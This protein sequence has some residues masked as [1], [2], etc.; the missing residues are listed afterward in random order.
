MKKIAYIEVDTHAEIARNFM[1]LM[2]GSTEFSVDYYFSKKI[3][4][5]FGV[6]LPNVHETES[7]ALLE[8]LKNKQ[9]DLLII[10]TVHRY[11]NVFEKITVQ[12]NTAVIVHNLNFTKISRFQLLKSLLKEDFTYRLKLLLKESLL[13]AP[14]VY[15][16]AEKLVLDENIGKGKLKFLPLFFNEF[17]KKNASEIFTVVIPGAVSQQRRDYL[18][19]LERIRNFNKNMRIVFLGKADGKELDWLKNF[20]K[21]KPKN[22]EIRYYTEKVPQPVFDEWMQNADVLWCPLQ[23][24]TPFF[25]RKELYGKTK[26]SGNIGDAIK[27]GKLAV[28]PENYTGKHPFIIQETIQIEEQLHHCNTSVNYDFQDKFSKE[29]VREGLEEIMNSLI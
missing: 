16:K 10:G 3:L 4:K 21:N 17:Q 6:N 29:K 28:F 20:E 15:R 5:Q 1:E 2:N 24:E 12:F 22:I 13:S 9:Y 11:F 27:F 19:V 23:K 25:N 26:M 7:S 18:S 8:Q 14:E